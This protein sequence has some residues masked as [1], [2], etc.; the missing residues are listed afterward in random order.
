MA[1]VVRAFD[2]E[3]GDDVALLGVDPDASV[4]KVKA[5]YFA[6]AKKYHPDRYANDPEKYKAA[7]EVARKITEAYDGLSALHGR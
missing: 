5:S 3:R 4:D 6:L 7:T 1:T 2:T